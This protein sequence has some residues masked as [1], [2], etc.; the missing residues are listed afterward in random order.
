[1]QR[2]EW[3]PVAMNTPNIQILVSKYSSKRN[4]ALCKI[5]WLLG[6]ELGNERWAWSM[7]QSQKSEK[8]LKKGGE[9]EV[10]WKGKGANL[11]ELPVAKVKSKWLEGWDFG[12]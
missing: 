4:K 11:N 1:M 9:I 2:H 3:L 7:L 12:W 10:Y 8:V 6:W 5:R